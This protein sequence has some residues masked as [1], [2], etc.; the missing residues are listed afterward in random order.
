[1]G[2]GTGGA[3]ARAAGLASA[4]SGKTK[5]RQL[6]GGKTAHKGAGNVSI[7]FVATKVTGLDFSFSLAVLI[8]VHIV[9]GC[10]P[11]N[12]FFTPESNE[13]SVCV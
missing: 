1:M 4:T 9:H 12:V 3:S 7:F 2:T 8:D 13:P 5:S 11:S 6:R 10:S